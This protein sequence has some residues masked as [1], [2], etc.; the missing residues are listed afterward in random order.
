MCICERGHTVFHD[1]AASDDFE[2]AEADKRDRL[3]LP[4]K[5]LHQADVR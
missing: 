1:V 2:S 5:E 3:G 4:P